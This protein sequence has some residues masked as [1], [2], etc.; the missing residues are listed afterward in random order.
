MI[1]EF[2]R[3]AILIFLV[4][5]VLITGIFIKIKTEKEL[6]YQKKR[7][8]EF[9]ILLTEYRNIKEELSKID[10]RTGGKALIEEINLLL[11][12][13]GLKGKVRSLKEAQK[14]ET[15]FGIIEET[16][17]VM[18]RLTMNELVNILYHVDQRHSLSISRI[19]MKRSF[20]SPEFLNLTVMLS[21]LKGR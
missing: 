8:S 6:A 12:T 7:L 3:T 9:R 20:D 10:K 1:K 15:S 17:L 21:G 14:K 4:L 5:T 18:E 19:S 11:H 13:T 16:E 2:Y